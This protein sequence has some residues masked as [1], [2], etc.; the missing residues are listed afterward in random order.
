[1]YPPVVRCRGLSLLWLW[2]ERRW[3]SRLSRDRLFFFVFLSSSST[4]S[5]S[6]LSPVPA[7]SFFSRFLVHRFKTF[8]FSPYC[9]RT[10]WAPEN[11][12][13]PRDTPF[14]SAIQ[15]SVCFHPFFV[16][17]FRVFGANRGGKMKFWEAESRM[18]ELLFQW[19]LARLRSADSLSMRAP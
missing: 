2:G 10:A 6:P 9:E 17:P 14:S 11:D 13:L 8:R 15:P 3:D 19:T 4:S 12:F 18:P 5:S 16:C 1:M 7:R